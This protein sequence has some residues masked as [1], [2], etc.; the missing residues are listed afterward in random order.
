MY[1]PLLIWKP[2]FSLLWLTNLQTH[3]RLIFGPVHMEPSQPSKWA[4]PGKWGE[5]VCVFIGETLSQ[6]PGHCHTIIYV[7]ESKM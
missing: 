5:N 4:G 2:I 6:Q 1:Q 3:K 7:P